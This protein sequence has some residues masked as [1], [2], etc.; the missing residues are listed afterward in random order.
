[1]QEIILVQEHSVWE[2]LLPLRD[3][4][5][6]LSG[7]RQGLCVGRRWPGEEEGRGGIRGRGGGGG[8]GGEER[9]GLGRRGG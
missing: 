1:M 6:A 2:E 4:L 5:E 7:P 3:G 9:E 8:G